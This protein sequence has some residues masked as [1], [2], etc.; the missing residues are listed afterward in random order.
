[1]DGP[2]REVLSEEDRQEIS[3]GLLRDWWMTAT[4]AFVDTAGSETA[5][6]HLRPHFI[7]A[8]KAAAYAIISITG[9]TDKIEIFEVWVE[10]RETC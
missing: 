4:Q 7:N 5:L 1:M 3:L 8:G 6:R 2:L 9:I 10:P